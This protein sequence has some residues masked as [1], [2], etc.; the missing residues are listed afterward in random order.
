MWVRI[1]ARVVIRLGGYFFFSAFV[2]LMDNICRVRVW[3]RV[4][5]R[6]MVRA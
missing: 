4:R 6:I 3:V 2:L 1:K 5:I